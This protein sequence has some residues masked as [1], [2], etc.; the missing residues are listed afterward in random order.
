MSKSY[1]IPEKVWGM[2]G[3]DSFEFDAGEITPKDAAEALILDYLVETGRAEVVAE[4][5]KSKKKEV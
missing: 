4:A 2:N 1:R 3:A 5:A